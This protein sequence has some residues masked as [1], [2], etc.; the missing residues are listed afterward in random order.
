MGKYDIAIVGMGCV[1]PSA[2]S[3][4]DY[5]NN[6]RSGKSFIKK[7]PRELWHMESY[8][9]ADKSRAEKTYTMV[10]SWVDNFEFPFLDYKFPP[11]ALK[12][13]DPCQLVTLE[14]T[15]EALLD[16]GIEPRSEELVDAC[17]I[18]GVSGVDGFAHATTYLRRRTYFAHLRP[19]L[20]K[21]GVP[22]EKIESLLEE[23]G[24]EL[25]NRGHTWNPSIAAVGAI[26]SSV[27]NR[28]AQVFGVK[29]YNM[30][31]DAA[32]AS[33]FVAIDVGCQALMSGDVNVA[34]AGGADLGTNPAIYVGFSRVDGLS[35]TGQSNPFDHTADGLIIGEGVGM[36]VLKRLEDAQR[37]GNRIR[38]VIRGIG[39]SSDGAGQAIYAPSVEGRMVALQRALVKAETAPDEVQFLEAHATSTIVGDANEYDAISRVY[40]PGREVSNPLYLGSVKHQIGHLKA[41]AGVAGLIKT[42]TA[43]E[44]GLYPH[45]PR[46]TKLTPGAQHPCEALIVPCELV[47][48]APHADGQKVAAITTS[49]FGGVNYHAIVEQGPKFKAPAARPDVA[50]DVAIVGVSVR[51]AG[52]DS[53]DGFWD[54]VING[55]ELFSDVNAEELGWEYNL[56]TGPQRE[57]IM[58]TRVSR[59]EDYDRRLL[60]HKIFPNAVSQVS[61]TQ[62]LALDLADRLLEGYGLDYKSSKAIAVSVGSMH[63]DYFPTIYM[64]MIL[65][66]YATSLLTCPVTAELGEEMVA[67]CTELASQS[68]RKEFP[69][70]T[71]HTL[72]GWMTNVTAGRLANKLNLSGPNFT[73]DTACS[74]G[75]AAL[76]PSIY[77]LMYGDVDMVISGGL[78]R[79]LSAEFT[80][81]VSALGALARDTARPFDEAGKGFLIGEGGVLF[82]LKRLADAERD[83]DDIFAVVRGL[84]G[85]SEADSKTMVAPTEAAIRRAIRN[86]LATTDIPGEAIGVVDTHGSANLLSDIAEA[87]SLA[88]E[89]RVN[90]SEAAPVQITAIKSHIGHL[91]GGSGASS[92]LSTIMSLRT[93]KVPGIRNLEKVRPELRGLLDRA[94]PRLGT[95]DLPAS[96]V[97]GGVNSLGL[98]GANYF[99]VV[100]A[101]EDQRS[102]IRQAEITPA[103]VPLNGNG[104]GEVR[105]S[106]REVEGIFVCVAS[107]EGDLALALWR[108]MQRSP[109]PQF[110]SEGSTVALRLTATYESESDLRSKLS[111]VL[112]M[113]EAGHDLKVLETQGV[114]MAKLS[115]GS[116]PEKLAFCFPGQGTHYITMGRHLYDSSPIFKETL[117]AVQE[118]V[119]STFQFDLL[120]HIYGDPDDQEI[121]TRLGSLVGAQTALFAIEL[122]V[123]RML[124]AMGVRPDVMV[125]HSFGEISALTVAGVWD[126][127]TALKVVEARIKATERVGKG[128]GPR[129][130]M[131]S[132]ICS[133][134]QLDAILDFSGGSV[135]LSNINAPGRYVVGGNMEAVK[136]AIKVAETFGANAQI[137]PIGAAFHSHFMEPARE[138]FRRAL[139]K[140]PCNRLNI[141]ILSTVTGEYL[142]P[143]KVT[144][145]YLATHLSNQLVTRLN[146][147][148]EVT[149][150]FQDGIRNF[151]EVGPGWSMS[152][153][154]AATLEGRAYRAVPTLH[155]K[156]GDVETLRRA[157]AFLSAY[158]HLPSVADRR[159]LPGMFT[160][161][162]LSYIQTNEPAVLGLL[163]E[164]QRRFI[165]V[166]QGPH[167]VRPDRRAVSPAPLAVVPPPS[168]PKVVVPPTAPPAP[169]AAAPTAPA[170][171]ATDTDIWAQRLKEKLVE[172]TGYPEEMLEDGLDLEADLGVDSVQRAEIWT[173]LLAEYDLDP[174][175]RPEGPRT[176]ENLAACLTELSGGSATAAAP[177]P[178]APAPAGAAPAVAD[179][180]I[181]T[182]R[183]KQKLVETTGYP[184]EM[185]EDGLDLEADLGVD[186]VQ[187]AE[188]WT[189]LLAEHDL[190]PEARPEGPRTIENL[191]ACLSAL[192]GEGGAVAAA[193]TPVAAAPV[194][195]A[196]VDAAS[197]TSI[198]TRRLKQKLVETTGYPEEM[199]EDGLDL[200]ADLGVDSVQRAE[201]WTS[202]LAEHDL[203]PEARPEGPRTIETLAICLAAIGA[204]GDT[205]PSSVD[206]PGADIDVAVDD[207]DRCRLFAPTWTAL[208]AG[209]LQ[210]YECAEALLIS[211]KGRQGLSSLLKKLKGKTDRLRVMDTDQLAALSAGDAAALLKTCDT[212]IYVAHRRLV[213]STGTGRK[214]RAEFRDH[215]K[216][217]F[218]SFKKLLP[219]LLKNPQRVLIPVTMDGAFGAREGSDRLLGAFPAGFARCLHYELPECTIQL[220][221]TGV[222][223]WDEALPR[224]IDKVGGLEMGMTFEGA[225]VPMV[226]PLGTPASTRK[227]LEKNDLVLVT[228]GARGIVFECVLALAKSTGCRLVLTG[229][230]KLPAKD[231]PWLSASEAE[232]DQVIRRMEIGLVKNKKMSLGKARKQAGRARLEWELAHNLRRVADAGVKADYEVCDVTD[233][234]KFGKL[235]GRLSSKAP[236]RGIVHGAGI[237]RSSL[238]QDLTQ[239]QIDLTLDTKLSPL[240]TLLDELDWNQL[241]L[242]SAFGSITGLFGNPGQTDYA[243]GND[244][245]SW[246]LQSLA[247]RHPEAHFQ[248]IDWT[249]WRG[250]GMV[251]DAEA[252]RFEESGLVPLTVPEGVSLYL[253]GVL[254]S[255]HEHLAAFNARAAFTSGRRLTSHQLSA[256]PREHLNA[257]DAKDQRRYA[258]LNLSQDVYL[259]QHKVNGEPVV[260]GAF[261]TELFAEAAARGKQILKDVRFRRP[262][263]VRQGELAV[264]VVKDGST[265]LLLPADRPDL[266]DKGLGNL[267]F[268]SCRLG[269]AGACD[270]AALELD[271]K[272]LRKLRQVAAETEVPFYTTLD[273]R[274]S[275]A[276]DTGPVFRGITATLEE[277]DRYYA[278]TRLT[279]EAMAVAAV[280]GRFVINPVLADMAVQAASSWSMLRYDVMAIPFEIG[281]LH[282]EGASASRDAV[283]ICQELESSPETSVVNVV[284][285]ELDGRLIFAF[286]RLT[287]KAIAGLPE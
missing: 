57:Q 89:L 60:K 140:L 181:W 144:S 242:F 147:V 77:Q 46:F 276:L 86:S 143:A 261:V 29:G 50:R 66:E 285:R 199:L 45:L 115:P 5:W 130:G 14:A 271:D 177:A 4:D 139:S 40:G 11:N 187:R 209:E 223:S 80:S 145:D 250:T 256:A 196:P 259:N 8:Y 10:G 220:V 117:D 262:L 28:V 136:R 258:T 133:E 211:E 194:A 72:P 105:R 264:E 204:S 70:V 269:R 19:A 78:N 21:R 243:L 47:E 172:T 253:D 189:S 101:P 283:V 221:D 97:A 61:P 83:G 39:S 190:D 207:D 201:I 92:L 49:G 246:A 158:G 193:P 128:R 52:A 73:V 170:P 120:G 148:R 268:A 12:G 210:P 239:K 24:E 53:A 125:G 169:A 184:E 151:L 280:P 38:A 109:I 251:T 99:A 68:M 2:N 275:H 168:P 154:V 175:A 254:G 197:D 56:D 226:S 153:M 205:A 171:A 137:L 228:G 3:V 173:S 232:I 272:R 121:A 124:T 63:D 240:F 233:D 188:I 245:L 33:S 236:I 150:L 152:K 69:P 18:I 17:T 229:R 41:A 26:P 43:M 103:A 161:D 7:A 176:I 203:D 167:A 202:L 231:S 214:L 174:E 237:Q 93:G 182:R 106:D 195:A 59:V 122:G 51:V 55:K 257:G 76:L 35:Q 22:A 267:S 96:S 263:A 213:E 241:R 98:G 48:W 248:T 163:Y 142:D 88:A 107:R 129:L 42:V 116:R 277:S 279:D 164:A 30:T 247:R 178:A 65:D 191:A 16:A 149:R 198:W 273:E 71:E 162:F 286:D 32:C 255:T 54:N 159:N 160:P 278:L 208:T 244:L 85:S 74:S 212:V 281:A 131:A 224:H 200:E 287:L 238:L 183:L 157:L 265:C 179:T 87:E 235:I 252:Q 185:L 114:F 132:V 218:S 113:L 1:F 44:N 94:E 249:A 110:F 108:A 155:P 225:A 119:H 234:V 146:L 260:P 134:Q 227:T 67:E 58:T 192:T 64:P 138:P 266:G 34:I 274:F 135:V 25:E 36:V 82:L 20:E 230:T 270:S 31:V 79:Q 23:F 126:I 111:G 215:V 219:A 84:S 13:V 127:D 118:A 95:T 9:S 100:T 91:Y 104:H 180:S 165:D 186:S 15:K 62:F 206:E 27:S 6:I 37:D 90:G 102:A 216:R 166:E 75:V 81:G 112:R 284:V 141:P 282:V 156:V 123:A 217:L 222:Q